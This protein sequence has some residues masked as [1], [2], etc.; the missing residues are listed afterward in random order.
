MPHTLPYHLAQITRSLPAWSKQLPK[1]QIGQFVQRLQK[2]YLDNDGNPCHWF[3]TAAEL[4]QQALRRAIAQRDATLRDLQALLADLQGISA[5]CTPLL[6]QRLA[7][8]VPVTQAQYRFQPTQVQ[9]PGGLPSGPDVPSEQ[10]PIIPRGQAQLRSLLEAALHNFEG[11][12]DTTRLSGLQVSRTDFSALPGLNL[13]DFIEQC[14]DLDL[15]QRYQD[16][17][18]SIYH[19]TA[20]EQI[21][22]LAIRAR[23]D[24]FRVQT[25]IARL[26]ELISLP[27]S[28]ALHAL[29]GNAPAPDYARRPLRTWQITLF[30]IPIHEMLLI[31]PA[32]N[33]KDDPVI[34]Y[35]PGADDPLREFISLGQVFQYM[36]GKLLD[37][38]FRKYFVALAPRALQPELM[39]R[40][41]RALF[42]NAD[43]SSG[44]KLISRTHIH[45]QSSDELLPS[46]P[47]QHLERS[48]V[49]RIKADARTIAVPTADVDARVRLERLE[50][51]LEV[52]LTLLNVAAMCVPVLNPLMLTIGAAQIMGSVFHG[53]EAWEEGDNAEALAQLQSVLLNLAVVGAV[54]GGAAALKASGFVDAMRSIRIGNRERLW[55]PTLQGYASP[56]EIPALQSPDARGQYHIDGR[57]YARVDGTLCEQFQ[58]H[59]GTWR[60]RHPQAPLAY[61]PP[62]ADNGAGAWRLADDSPLEWD[63]QTLLRRLGRLDDD[64]SQQALEHAWRSGPFDDG[65]LQRLHLSGTKL[66]AAFE[67]ALARLKAERQARLMIEHVRHARPL[68]AYKNF[69]VPALVELP[70]WP[71]N[72]VIEVFHGPERWG[73]ATR[74]GRLPAQSGDVFVQIS[75]TE[76]D[77][78]ELAEAVL[79]QLQDP[80]V[81]SDTS[82][83]PNARSQ[84]LQNRLADHLEQRRQGITQSLYQSQQPAPTAAGT[85]LSGQFPGLPSLI[86]EEV[87]SHASVLERQQIASASARIPLRILE[88]ARRLQAQLRLDRA[89]LGL[90]QP[91]LATADSDLLIEGLQA[92][93]PGLSGELLFE[94]A[95]NDRAQ[96]ARLIGQ[97]PIQPGYR[98][99]LRLSHGRL[100]YPLSGRGVPRRT[101]TAPARRLQ[102]LYPEL[103]SHQLSELQVELAQTNDIANAIRQLETE[104][105]V[106]EQGLRRWV[107]AAADILEREERQQ[108]AEVLRH[109]WRR[110]GGN[111]RD[112]LT[113]ERMRLAE[114]PPLTARFPHIRSLN[115]EAQVLERVE[116]QFLAC[117]PNLER[118][119]VTGNPRLNA[120]AVIQAL[121]ATPKLTELTITQTTLT[122]LSNEARHVLSMMPRLRRLDLRRNSIQ[123]SEADITLLG[124]LQ[125]EQLDLS[126]NRIALDQTLAQRFQDI[127]HLRALNLD[128]NP[129]QTAPDLRYMARLSELSMSHCDLQAWPDGLTTLMSQP[130]YQLRTLELSFNRIHTLPDLANVLRTP[131]ARD[132]AAHLPGRRWRFSYNDM[133]E[134]TRSRLLAT[135]VNVF[136]HQAEMPDWQTLWRTGASTAREQLWASLFEQG[137][138]SDLAGVLERLSHSAEAQRQP[139]ALNGRV[140]NLLEQA[141]QDDT[142]RQD[143]NDLAQAFPPTCGD[144]GAD[145]F[146]ALEIRLLTYHASISD[147]PVASQLALYGKLYRRAQVDTLAERIALRRTIRKAALQ[148]AQVTGDESNLPALDPLDDVQAVP[149]GDLIDAL[150]DDIEIRLALRQRLAS[151][152][153][154]PEPSAGMLYEQTAQLTPQILRNVTA[155]I[156]RLDLDR[157]ARRAWMIEQP[158]WQRTLRQQYA[159]QFEAVTDYWRDGL[160]YLD[161]CLDKDAEPVTSLSSSLVKTL[162][163]VLGLSLRDSQGALQRVELNSAQYQLALDA[164]LAEQKVVEQ[165]LLDSLTRGLQTT[166]P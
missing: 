59:D 68:A 128:F 88:E 154:Y 2:D 24:E 11:L 38:A 73:E 8:D 143:L 28:A 50:H 58:D 131:F 18:A 17:L 81:F 103:D 163:D 100:G 162:Q 117:F 101:G 121:L 25:R 19:G 78:G 86:I 7:I 76:L 105:S 116:G 34:L 96:A 75:R 48:H 95:A 132:L 71:E 148:E 112:S 54:G 106:L 1:D 35:L 118:L 45:L 60:V 94:A 12:S 141:A 15:G 91:A 62:L 77:N 29:C 122:S 146:S 161:Y 43:N 32:E 99:P 42:T 119:H 123:L 80:A 49:E 22:A 89:I 147:S 126:N 144:A 113:L 74:Y 149:D 23:R 98:S 151:A 142:L 21:Q 82:L 53:I 5:F 3:T 111:I 33:G 125:L 14:R 64:L 51:W 46:Q 56:I 157:D 165:G 66:P 37:E 129:L 52:G 41:K 134:Q 30:G 9:Q 109:A 36:R 61:A 127:I 40:L 55:H 84:A 140:W 130:Q 104:R 114:L 16:H 164:L 160:D 152:L 124:S 133:I 120:N 63:R 10:L 27:A 44:E 20:A 102:M 93:N 139:E 107:D 70:G 72:H 4:D 115:I 135:G 65:V 137:E 57:T 69:A 150:V 6:Q 85:R 67:D 110:E 159:P 156:R 26:K 31:A 153:D 145:A 90:Y 155:E 92:D 13:T 138:N 83:A 79:A 136:E 87:V 108:C 97:Q 158:S 47:W 166:L 39:T